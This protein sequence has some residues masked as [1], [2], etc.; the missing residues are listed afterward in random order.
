MMDLR[1]YL[2]FS[3]APDQLAG[4]IRSIPIETPKGRFWVWA[5]REGNK[6]RIRVL[7]LHGGPG[8]THELHEGFD[9]YLP[10]KGTAVET[11]FIVELDARD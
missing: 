11:E 9:G 5:K 7:L 10:A 6:P 3:R 8:A 4:G 1:N 2:D